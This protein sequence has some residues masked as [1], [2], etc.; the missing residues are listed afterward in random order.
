MVVLSTPLMLEYEAVLTRPEMLARSGM[1]AQDVHNLL[2]DLSE[3]CIPVG[4]DYRYRPLAFD[5]DDDLVLETAVNGQAKVIATFNIADFGNGA[6]RFGI[7]V[8]R[9]IDVLRRLG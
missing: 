8:E 2:D 7:A 4:F 6:V 5:P 1:A 9:P 3:L